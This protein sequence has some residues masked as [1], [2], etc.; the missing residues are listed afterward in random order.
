MA[1][2]ATSTDVKCAFSSGGL[3]VSKMR[4]SLS[5]NSVRATTVVGSW[6]GF[7]GAIPLDKIMAVFKEKRKRYK[8]TKDAMVQD[9]DEDVLII[10]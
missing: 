4:H 10:E 8:G 2:S 9:D 3:T 5:E 7:D 1:L 6:A